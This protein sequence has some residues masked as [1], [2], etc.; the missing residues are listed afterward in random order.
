MQGER[1]HTNHV[2][3]T[4]FVCL[5]EY[6]SNGVLEAHASSRKEDFRSMRRLS[7]VDQA[8]D[9]VVRHYCYKVGLTIKRDHCVFRNQIRE[10]LT[11]YRT[12]EACSFRT[13]NFPNPIWINSTLTST[14]PS[15]VHRDI[16]SSNT[17]VDL[18]SIARTK[19]AKP[20]KQGWTTASP[21]TKTKT[22]TTHSS[23]AYV[24]D[25][26]RQGRHKHKDRQ[27][28]DED[29]QSEQVKKKNKDIG[30]GVRVA[31]TSTLMRW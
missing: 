4:I 18:P 31:A 21:A 9:V 8:F 30:A 29:K 3:H 10:E 7:A 1:K 2:F 11:L 24:H 12:C 13:S 25:S 20:I 28:Q 17:D 26:R 14:P 23:Q 19:R 22:R 16:D 15:N 5:V 27:I 6:A